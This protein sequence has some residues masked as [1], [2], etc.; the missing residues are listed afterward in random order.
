MKPSIWAGWGAGAVG[1]VLGI[2]L[3]GWGSRAVER[4]AAETPRA[5]ELVP[6]P[7]DVDSLTGVVEVAHDLDACAPECR[8]I[9]YLWTP[10]MPLS[11][12]GIPNVV[13]AARTLGISITL[14]STEELQDYAEGR[15]PAAGAIPLAEAML[16]AGVLAHAPALVV[17]ADGDV[18]GTAILGYKNAAAYTSL[19]SRRLSDPRPTNARE[20]ETVYARLAAPPRA[21]QVPVD[22]DVV[23]VPGAYFRWVPGTQILAYESDQ[24]VYLLDLSDRVSRVAP[25]HIDFVPTPDGRYFV[26]PGTDGLDFFDAAEVI[27]AV[28]EDRSRDVEPIFTDLRMRDQYPSVGILERGE[29]RTVYRILTSWFEGLVY[30]DYEVRVNPTTGASSVRPVGEAVVP[31]VGSALSTPIMS[32]T[33]LEVAARDESTGTTKVFEI[34]EGG[35][36]EEVVNLGALTSKVAWDAGGRRL[37]F[38]TPARGSGRMAEAGIFVF[39]L[40]AGT[41]IRVPGSEGASRLAFP[42]FIGEGSVVFLVPALQRGAKSVFRVVDGIR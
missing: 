7:A 2:A 1:T 25:G 36:C 29:S 22:Y 37:A 20:S 34:L 14:M 31:C 18:L 21:P 32:Q 23:G 27:D 3:L 38:A 39:D 19:V 30:R 35:L 10:R 4:A 26:T 28:R 42:E 33:G 15:H 6:L 12:S 17:H 24:R 13:E 9:V 40:D 11:R 41:T 8:G 16:E 5:Y